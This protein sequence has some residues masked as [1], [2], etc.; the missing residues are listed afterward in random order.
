MANLNTAKMKP[1]QLTDAELAQE[2]AKVQ[3][4]F[5]KEEMVDYTIP[6]SLEG[7]I[8]N[9]FYWPLNGVV[10]GF[11]LGKTKKVPKPVAEHITDMLNKLQ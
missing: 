4:K 1:A 5:L 11:E 2:Q 9:P 10:I 6:L 7:K 3:E 8:S